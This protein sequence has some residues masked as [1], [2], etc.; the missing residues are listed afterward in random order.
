MSTPR[1]PLLRF[2]FQGNS[3]RDG[4]ILYDDLTTFISNISLA[5]DRIINK[6]LT[7]ESVKRGRPSKETKILTALEIVSMNKGSFEVG[8]D[9]RRNGHQFP[10]WDRGEEAV[11]KLV[12]GLKALERRQGALPAEYDY[13][14]LQAVRDAGKIMDRGVDFIGINAN[15]S[16]GRRRAHYTPPLRRKIEGTLK[17]LELGLTTVEGRL[18]M[19][20]VEEDKLRCRLRPTTGEPFYCS[21]DEVLAETID[22]YLRHFVRVHGNAVFDRDT[23]KILSLKIMD[24]ESIDEVDAIGVSATS[25]SAFWYPKNFEQLASEQAVYPIDDI[26]KLFGDWPEG[27]DFNG[28]LDAVRSSKV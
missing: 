21:Y 1:A 2:K 14:V 18:V 8:L 22:K 12:L 10:G 3:I 17:H 20:D 9:L 25:P 28:F 24:L 27:E 13:G 4:R 6:M 5:V 15:S 19:L 7:G 16:F 23:N 11:F 26:A